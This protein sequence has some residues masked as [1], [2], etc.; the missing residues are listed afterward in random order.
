MAY[1]PQQELLQRIANDVGTFG[2]DI[3]TTPRQVAAHLL[4]KRDYFSHEAEVRMIF[5]SH[6]ETTLPLKDETAAGL[7]SVSFDPNELFDEISVDPRLLG[8]ERN[9]REEVMR[10]LG[11]TGTVTRRDHYQK[12]IV[13]VA[14]GA[15]PPVVE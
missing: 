3:Y 5:V 14:L 8:F 10:N 11:Y 13:D 9:E 12:I 6:D 2:T 1:S 15:P 7:F 4:L